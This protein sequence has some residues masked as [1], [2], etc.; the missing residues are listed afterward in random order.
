M[1]TE[2]K[3]PRLARLTEPYSG[4]YDSAPH[5]QDGELAKV[6][7]GTAGGEYLRRYWQPVCLTR[8]LGDL[9]KLVWILGEELVL[10]RDKRGEYGL[11]HKHCPHRL[12]SLEYGII[13]ECGITCPYHGWSFD[14]DGTI[15]STPGEPPESKLK[16]RLAHGAYPVIEFNGIIFAYLGPPEEKPEFPFYDSF[17]HEDCE[18]HPY[19]V[20][21]GCNWMQA[22]DNVV[23]QMHVVF[24]HSGMG[25]IQFNEAFAQFPVLEFHEID[26]GIVVTNTKRVGDRIWVRTHDVVLPNFNQAGAITTMDASETKLFGRNA[27]SR[28]VVALDDKRSAVFGF[29][30][31]HKRGDPR[32]TAT[33]ELRRPEVIQRS[34]A[35]EPLDRPYEEQQRNPG[36]FEMFPSQGIISDRTRE[37]LGNTDRGIAK[38]RSRHRRD[39]KAL[40]EKGVQ[41]YHSPPGVINTYG[42]DTVLHIP[43][44]D[45]ATDRELMADIAQKVFDIYRSVDHLRGAERYEAAEAKLAE[46]ET[47]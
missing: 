10:F 43:M 33:D 31:F 46:L 21:I 28:W 25:T 19:M 3:H 36:D 15:L 6:G 5:R 34:E 27:L 20:P 9:P 13:Q 14:V 2:E 24:L 40:D 29:R 18:M 41:P 4:Y 17:E 12:A 26:N 45:E 39:V 44:T 7:P 32:E 23:D 37:H 30:Q 1:T 38:L 8:D 11:V 42:G 22:W 47:S 35:G 16:E